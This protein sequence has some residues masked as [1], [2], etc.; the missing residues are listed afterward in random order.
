[1]GAGRRARAAVYPG[2]V[3][4]RLRLRLV[5]AGTALLLAAAALAPRPACAQL[6][7][8]T[9]DS[10]AVH[11]VDDVNRIPEPYRRRAEQ[12]RA[13][14]DD[15]RVRAETAP[16]GES[17]RGLAPHE[18]WRGR[19]MADWQGD[20]RD[21]APRARVAALSGLAFF[22]AAAVP[23]MIEALRDPD[24][25]VRVGAARALGQ[26]G[27]GAVEALVPLGQALRDA[28]ARVRFD[29]AVA[30][31][32][33]GPAAADGVPGL[34]RALSDPAGEVRVGAAM[35]LGGIGPA[36]REAMPALVQ[37][38]REGNAVL[39]MSAASAIGGIGP[40]ARG[41]VPD[42]RAA[43]RDGNTSVRTSAAMALGSIGP[44][45]REAIPDLRRLAD[46]DPAQDFDTPVRDGV[47]RQKQGVLRQE[48]RVAAR[49]A[50]RQIEGR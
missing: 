5:R 33:I 11:L 49:E 21:A 13:A 38:L 7:R 24:A 37:A 48:M 34:R 3:S 14:G 44:G 39:R 32:R 22:G 30:L 26:V 6:Y 23:G 9:D 25:Q 20:L 4:A 29:A 40:D 50:L 19:T 28:D 46:S 31:G 16:A 35:G 45:A 2:A 41:A 42:L 8:W 47:L 17:R 27:P 36:A 12:L 18:R 15:R 10:G 43:L 1:M